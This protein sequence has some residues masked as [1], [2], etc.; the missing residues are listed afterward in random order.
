MQP[1]S[2]N[3]ITLRGIQTWKANGDNISLTVHLLVD[4]VVRRQNWSDWLR[5]F[6]CTPAIYAVHRYVG[7]QAQVDRGLDK[8]GVS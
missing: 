2:S 6:R 1:T 7:N 8:S 5:N 3:D 4:G